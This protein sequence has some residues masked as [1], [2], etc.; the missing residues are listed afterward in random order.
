MSLGKGFM[1]LRLLRHYRTYVT[2]KPFTTTTRKKILE[3]ERERER[4]K[5]II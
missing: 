5:E 2:T 3:G 1:S 4:E